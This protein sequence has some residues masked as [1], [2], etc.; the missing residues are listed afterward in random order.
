MI[1]SARPLLL[2]L[3]LLFSIL[4]VA[5]D[6]RTVVRQWLEQHHSSLGLTEKDATDWTVTSSTTTAMTTMMAW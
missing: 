6:A 2:T 3:M 5:Q 1:R 4:T